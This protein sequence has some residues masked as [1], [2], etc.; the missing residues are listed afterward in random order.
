VKKCP[1]HPYNPVGQ[2]GC[3]ECRSEAHVVEFRNMVAAAELRAF[4][5]RKMAREGLRLSKRLATNDPDIY[6]T[7]RLKE[8]RRGAKALK[9]QEQRA[10]EDF[11]RGA[12]HGRWEVISH[13]PF[14][15]DD[16][17]TLYVR[18]RCVCGTTQEYAVSAARKASARQGEGWG[19]RSRK[20]LNK[21]REECDT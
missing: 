7:S 6:D 9:K 8:V 13:E 1:Q 4:E 5:R 21:W 19:C 20:C 10:R 15:K 3:P 17:R 14:R 18:M 12:R 11:P 16:G 2:N